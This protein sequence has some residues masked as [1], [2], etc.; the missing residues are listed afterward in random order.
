MEFC[1]HRLA[2]KTKTKYHHPN[3]KEWTYRFDLRP[4]KGQILEPEDMSTH[5][6]IYFTRWAAEYLHWS[7]VHRVAELSFQRYVENINDY[8]NELSIR[9]RSK[10]EHGKFKFL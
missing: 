10:I 1:N 8:I 2:M 5:Q 3:S 7:E 6:L 4:Y 9:K